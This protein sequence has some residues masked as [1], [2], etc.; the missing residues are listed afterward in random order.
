MIERA[1]KTIKDLIHKLILGLTLE[2]DRWIDLLPKVVHLYNE[3]HVHST[4][5]M[6]PRQALDPNNKL[7]VYMNIQSKAKFDMAFPTLRVGDKVRTI[8]KIK[9][10][11]KAHHP[12]CSKKLT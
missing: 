5:G 9:A 12:K 8:V 11:T 7:Q 4:I 6:T 10:M 2:D 3:K 1:I